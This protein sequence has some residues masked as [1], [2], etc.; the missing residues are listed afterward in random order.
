VVRGSAIREL[1]S[2]MDLRKTGSDNGRWIEQGQDR[3]QRRAMTSAVLNLRDLLQKNWLIN[4][5]GVRQ[6]G[7][8]DGIWLELAQDR[9]Q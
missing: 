9:A 3:V 6:M 5:T 2:R 7:S 4:M 1:I 8:D